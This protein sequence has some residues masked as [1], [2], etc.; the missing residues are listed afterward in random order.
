MPADIFYGEGH[1]YSSIAE[2]CSP[3]CQKNDD[4]WL[5]NSYTQGLILSFCMSERLQNGL[6]IALLSLLVLWGGYTFLQYIAVPVHQA[7]LLSDAQRQAITDSCGDSAVCTQWS[8]IVPTITNTLARAGTFGWYIVWSIIGFCVLLG[9]SFMKH[10]DWRLRLNMNPLKLILTFIALLWVFFTV[11]SNGDLGGQPYRQVFL[12][13][14]AVYP[15]ADPQTIQ[16][17][18]DDYNLLKERGCL[19]QLQSADQGV[20]I[21]SVKTVCVQEAFFTRV[22]T[23]VLSILYL[24]FVVLSFGRLLLKWLRVPV[25]SAPMEA[26]FSAGLG[27]CGLIVVLWTLAVVGLYTQLA[28]WIVLLGLPLLTWKQSLYWL[29]S[30]VE[31]EWTYDRP[32]HD[33]LL[34]L[35]WL[36]ITYILFNFLTV[37]RPFPIGWDDLG[38]Y[39]NDPR[40]IVSYGH[41]I[42]RMSAFQWE[43]ITS[44]GFLLFGYDSPFGATTSM[45]INWMAGL[46]ALLTVYVF[47]SHY[48]GKRHG[49]LAALL[50]YTLPVIGHFSFA[51]MKVDNAVFTMGALAMFAAF[52]AL[53]PGDEESEDE[54]VFRWQWVV[55]AGLFVGFGF[56]MKPTVVM[57]MMTVFS[58]FLGVLLQGWAFVGGGFLAWVL[59]TK[60]D[61]FHPSDFFSKV[62]GNPALLSTTAVMLICA[63]IGLAFVGYAAY[64]RPQRIKHTL[65]VLAVFFGVAGASIMPWILHNN[66]MAGRVIPRLM[67]RAPNISAPEFVLDGSP[68]AAPN[69]RSLPADLLVNLKGEGCVGSTSKSEELDRYWGY[70]TGISH[71]LGLPWRSVMNADS[72][73]YYVTTMPGLLLFPLILLLPFFWTKRGRWLRWLLAATLFLILQWIFFANGILWYGIGMFLGLT[74]GLE[75]LVTRAPDK[76]TKSIAAIALFLSFIVVFGNRFWQFETQRNL[77]TYPLGLVSAGAMEERTI[78]HYNTIR[79]VVENRA[80]DMPNAPYVFRIGTFIPYFIPK[81]L[82]LLPVAD[83]QLNLFSCI[84]QGKDAQ[85]TIKRLKALGFNSI[86]FDTNTQTIEKDPNGTLHKKVKEFLDFVNT[87]GLGLQVVVNDVEGGIAFLLLP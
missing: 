26:I 23:E 34:P 80:A 84:N 60:Q 86:I 52:L 36:L 61:V 7:V 75:A 12:P 22:F 11:L 35:V 15:T 10:G 47:A 64:L 58:L 65:L 4:L 87:P 69:T 5:E 38:V 56:A 79:D 43:Y 73:G 48:F 83:N 51:D 46:L 85:L 13:N 3:F 81:N 74:V 6:R 55:L 50:Y 70:G 19:T 14:S 67:L 1:G 82:E 32:W 33:A 68:S 57:V 41:F 20:E 72:A 63:V 71:Y 44:I 40:L 53:F 77:Y 54:P 62:F 39:L 28:G 2:N 9:M 31:T 27:A 49:V 16:I 66:I 78:P 29:R 45:L 76:S 24:L 18:T 42:P 17:L 21:S 59:F 25:K 37:V 8:A 30:S